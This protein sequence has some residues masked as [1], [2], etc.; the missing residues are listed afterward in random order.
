M[1]P[2]NTFTTANYIFFWQVEEDNG[3]LSNWYPA[4]FTAEGIKYVNTEQYM[5]A[6][7]A[8]LFGDFTMYARIMGTDDPAKI[9]HYGK[10]VS[11][12]DPAVWNS[13]KEEIM[14]NGNLAKFRCNHT[15]AAALRATGEAT[16]AEASPLDYVWGIGL[17]ADDPKATNPYYWKGDNLLGKAL[18]KVRDMIK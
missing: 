4:P 13:A 1:S 7:K 11:N 5:M 15:L 12:F 17:K 6:K 2:T 18:M 10:L 3:Y 14:F 16:L 9:K 8:L